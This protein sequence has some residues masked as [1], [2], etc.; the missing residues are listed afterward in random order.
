[1]QI[2]SEE[3]ML[4]EK[5]LRNKQRQITDLKSRGEQ[6]NEELMVM[7]KTDMLVRERLDFK[8]QVERINELNKRNIT[9]ARD[10]LV[11]RRGG[12]GSGMR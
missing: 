9:E 6:Y 8:K 3:Q 1:M 10:D 4:I 12:T 2:Q 11:F 5:Q 7:M